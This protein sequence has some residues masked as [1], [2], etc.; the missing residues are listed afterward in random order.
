MTLHKQKIVLEITYERGFT[1][2]PASWR[3]VSLLDLA[4]NE[5]CRLVSCT[6][7]EPVIDIPDEW[8]EGDTEPNLED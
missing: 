7:P 1:T 3:W 8:G 5:A 6:V 2:D 4:P